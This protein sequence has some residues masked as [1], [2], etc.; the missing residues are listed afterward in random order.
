MCVS[1]CGWKAETM[2]PGWYR[3]PQLSHSQCWVQVWGDTPILPLS[4]RDTKPLSSPGCT[5]GIP[6]VETP[7]SPEPQTL[8]Q[9]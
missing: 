8:D 2:Q 1:G 4:P 9:Q 6:S 7:L 5:G 3:R